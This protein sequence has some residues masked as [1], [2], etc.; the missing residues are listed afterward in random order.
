MKKRNV[1]AVYFTAY[2]TW[3]GCKMAKA[4]TLQR[5]ARKTIERASR[6]STIRTLLR[7]AQPFGWD[8]GPP[9]SAQLPQRTTGDAKRYLSGYEYA[10]KL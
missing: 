4:E 1:A 2:D 6:R 10:A 9:P 5:R 7:F 3:E 8:A